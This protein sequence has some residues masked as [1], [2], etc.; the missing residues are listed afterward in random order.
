M[1]LPW[2]FLSLLL[3][4]E[5]KSDILIIEPVSDI[6]EVEIFSN[7]P[8]AGSIFMLLRLYALLETSLTLSL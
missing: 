4:R 8:S 3:T 6:G 5:Y 1:L 7:R 2:K